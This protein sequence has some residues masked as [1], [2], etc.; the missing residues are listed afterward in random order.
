MS[1]HSRAQA[2]FTLIE[3]LVAITLM[4]LVSLISWQGLDAVQ[5]TQEHLDEKG[6]QVMAMVRVLGQ[7]EHD[8]QQHAT[9]DVLPWPPVVPEQAGN[10]ANSPVLSR[11]LPPGIAW[12]DGDGLLLVRGAGAGGWQQVR[13]Y[14]HENRL[15]RAVGQA[16][17][18]LPLPDVGTAHAVLD[19]VGAMRM[20]V[21]RQS[22]GWSA[23]PGDSAAPNEPAR[24][25]EIRLSYVGQ[26]DQ[27]AFRKVVML[28]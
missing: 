7:L 18:Q 24:A 28:P 19:Q 13:W 27:Q 15:M 3:V 25:V 21:W 26:T 16:S 14:V 11:L 9:Q 5:R 12:S 4:A 17:V 2:G 23:L 8:L 10:Q 20:R 22:A 1:P 6:Q